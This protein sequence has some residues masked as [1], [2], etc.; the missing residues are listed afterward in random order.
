MK[1]ISI[2]IL[3]LLLFA[4]NVVYAGEKF[5][6]TI[7]PRVWY[8]IEDFSE[9]CD[10]IHLPLAGVTVAIDPKIW[11]SIDFVATVIAG[12]AQGDCD[13][14][15]GSRSTFDADRLDI[16][17]LIRKRLS[18]ANASVF[19]GARSIFFTE[20]ERTND[21]VFGASGTGFIETDFMIIGAE[22]G[23]SGSV[24][25]TDN[26]RHALFLNGIG[27]L[28]WED[29]EVQNRTTSLNP[30]DDGFTPAI[31]LNLGYQ[32]VFGKQVSAHVR[33]R[34]FVFY[35]SGVGIP[36]D[37]FGVIHGPEIGVSIR[38]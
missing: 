13:F 23:F 22:L 27:F 26:G 7:T 36:D 24:P 25:L 28:A 6:V 14:G 19:F 30:D 12:S 9:G 17:F 20:E 3:M 10:Q 33:Y 34:A 15:G 18:N 5:D 8:T 16:E 29:S 35:D 31:D 21:F 37:E 11:K 4:F 2:F 1:N 38:F 32:Y